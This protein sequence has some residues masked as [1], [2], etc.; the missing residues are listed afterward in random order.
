VGTELSLPVL[1]F[2]R[3]TLS[4]ALGREVGLLEAAADHLPFKDAAFDV[5]L[6]SAV[7]LC[8]GPRDIAPSLAEI[9]R[10]AKR[11]IVLAEPFDDDPMHATSDGVPDYYPNTTYWIRNYIGL[12]E[13]RARFVRVRHLDK[14][15]QIG[16]LRSV[17]VF[18][19]LS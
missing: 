6:V 9:L 10:V 1:N 13:A 4:A 18:E 8:I 2:A 11:W 5:V 3:R 17:L 16:H 15:D 14:A 7:L 19:K 12:L